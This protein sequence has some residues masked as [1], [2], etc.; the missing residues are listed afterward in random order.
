MKAFPV[1][2]ASGTHYEVGQAIGI[3]RQRAITDILRQ[4]KERFGENLGRFLEESAEFLV[5]AKTYYP[6]YIDELRGIADGAQVSFEELF[7]SNNREVTEPYGD[8]SPNHCTIIGIPYRNGYLLGHNEDWE[9]SSLHNLYI[10]DA[11]I[12]GVRIFGLNYANSLFGVSV[13][14][15]QFGL[16][17]AVNE[18]SHLDTQHGVPKNFIA[19]AI[20]DCK[21]LEEAEAIVASVP[22]AAGFNHVVI[23]GDR[24]WN[25]ESSAQEYI[26]EKIPH[27][28]YVHTNHYVTELTRLDKGNRESEQRYDKVKRQLDL[29]GTVE[30]MKALLSDRSEP[31][32]CRDET[33][34]SV[35]FDAT[36]N[37][38]YIA[39]GQPTKD[40]YYKVNL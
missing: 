31:P 38:A 39:F 40:A 5:Q 28:K 35:I 36:Q 19:R 17:E 6:H 14:T 20:L 18:L 4:H 34:G 25:I 16:I 2:R 30:D 24:L 12:D 23:Q 3:H 1:V 29:M 21:T 37:V 32:I 26:I 10:F 27:Q 15:N 22:R 13:A 11:T 33:I 9:P 8:V 7:L